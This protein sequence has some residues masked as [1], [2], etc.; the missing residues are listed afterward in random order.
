VVVKDIVQDQLDLAREH[1]ASLYEGGVKRGKLMAEEAQAGM[2]RIDYTLHYDPLRDLDLVIEAVPE[3]MRIKKA[4]LVELEQ[5]CAPRTIFA[6]NTSALSI[7]T[8]GRASCRPQRM[9]GM[10]FFNPA[11]RMKLVEVIPT[12]DT[13]SEIVQ[14][15]VHLARGLGKTPVVVRDSPGFLVNRLLMPYLNEAI[16]FLQEGAGSVREIDATMGREGFGWPMGPFE[17]MDMLGLDVCHHIITYLASQ[18]G[19]R[20]AE[21]P[22]LEALVRS[23]RLGEKTG[24]G[25]YDYPGGR[26]WGGI[27]ELIKSLERDGADTHTSS[28]SVDRIM[29]RFVN[30][31]FLCLGEK[32]ADREDIDT[33]CILGLGMAVSLGNRRVPMGPLA[34]AEHI[35]LHVFVERLGRLESLLGPRFQPAPELLAEADMGSDLGS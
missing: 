33:A 14:A 19:E 30:E 35:G 26:A 7:S 34:Y 28:F 18:F 25:F 29:A 11:H 22:L 13:G 6:S 16:R 23:G 12:R 20:M 21:A 32:V 17:L 3:E 24:G 5:V 2:A 31:A 4:V 27:G 1:V 15:I 9:I 8:M 10:H